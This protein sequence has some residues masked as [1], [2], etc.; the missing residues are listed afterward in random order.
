MPE[1]NTQHEEEVIDIT[2]TEQEI[3]YLRSRKGAANYVP[4]VVN[5]AVSV[6]GTGLLFYTLYGM[7]E[8]I[9]S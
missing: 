6:G 8:P 5:T 2:L 3:E 9:T 4:H 7:A 1:S